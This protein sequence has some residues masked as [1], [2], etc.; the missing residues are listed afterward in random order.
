M[1]CVRLFNE[2]SLLVSN[3]P[4]RKPLVFRI[5]RLAQL[6][7][8]AR[9]CMRSSGG[10]AVKIRIGQW[11]AAGPSMRSKWEFAMIHVRASMMMSWLLNGYIGGDLP[12]PFIL[13]CLP[14]IVGCRCHWGTTSYLARLFRSGVLQVGGLYSDQ[15]DLGR[16]ARSANP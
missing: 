16:L 11:K 6:G 4:I 13:F 5:S 9:E 2:V 12:V 7:V 15:W 8:I 3:P 14:K 1:I 10:S